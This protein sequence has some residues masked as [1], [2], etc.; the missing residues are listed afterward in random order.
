MHCQS[1]NSHTCNGAQRT[2]LQ[3][4]VILFWRLLLRWVSAT[5][6]RLLR[7]IAGAVATLWRVAALLRIATTIAALWL[8]GGVGVFEGA[9]TGLRVDKEPPLVTLVPFGHPRWREGWR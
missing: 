2:I 8:I 3:S 1:T 6:A 9:L 7:R 5:V 4:L